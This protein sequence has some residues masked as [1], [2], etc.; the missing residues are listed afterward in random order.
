MKIIISMF[1]DI[2]LGQ[3]I[4]LRKLLLIN[5]GEAKKWLEGV[6]DGQHLGI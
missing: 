4:I 5:N 3:I 1:L 2:G 6:W